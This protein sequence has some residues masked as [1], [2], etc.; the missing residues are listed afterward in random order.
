[1]E[2]LMKSKQLKAELGETYKILR[3]TAAIYHTQKNTYFKRIP[4]LS[5][6]K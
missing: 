6:L 5:E 2:V 3:I 1:M 4:I